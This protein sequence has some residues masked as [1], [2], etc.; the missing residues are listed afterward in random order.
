MVRPG[1]RTSIRK[2]ILE[3]L[4]PNAVT[5]DYRPKLLP[6]WGEGKR[7]HRQLEPMLKS[8]MEGY[9]D[10]L[11]RFADFT[12]T[13]AAG[14]GVSWGTGWFD[15]LDAV[16]LYSM[17]AWIR[18]NR[19]VEIGSGI[20][21]QFARKAV[22]DHRLTTTLTSID[23]EPRAEIDAICD[24][25]IRSGLENVDLPIFDLLGPGDFLFMDGSHRVL[26]NSD[27][28]VFFLEVL[29]RLKPGVVV[30]MHDIFLPNDYPLR[31]RE[32]YYSEQYMLAAYLLAGEKLKVLLPNAFVSTRETLLPRIR[33]LFVKPE[34]A[35]VGGLLA[36]TDYLGSSFWCEV[37]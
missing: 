2:A 27:A 14:S 20:S 28:T 6:R 12:S 8:G 30:H 35:Q 24:D 7:P 31:W 32:L 9:A 3:R 36:Q 16:A 11:S 5:I 33:P 22:T 18:P 17:M 13:L 34:M 25:V 1:L 26:M 19:Y 15:A 23:P 29:P 21:T 4:A 10:V 37:R